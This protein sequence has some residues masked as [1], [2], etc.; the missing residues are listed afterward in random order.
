MQLGMINSAWFGSPYDGRPGLEKMKEIGFDAVDV[1]ADPLDL[2]A[3]RGRRCVRDV[4][5]VG[6]A[7]PSV[8]VVAFG[9]SDFNP[10]I[11]RFHLDRAKG[12]SISASSSGAKLMVVALGEYIW[13]HEV[14]PPEAQWH[15]AVDSTRELGDYAAARGL[16]LA[17]ELEP[18]DISTR[19]HD[20]QAREVHRRRRPPRRQGEPRLLASLAD[21]TR[22]LRDPQ[23][24]GKDHPHALLR[25]QRRDPRRSAARTWQH[26]A[27]PLPRGARARRSSTESSRSSWSTPRS[28]TRSS[29]GSRKRTTQPPR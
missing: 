25:L 5:E 18:F 24:Q 29:S 20:R 10:S 23:A 26:A 11:R 1:L 15:W 3:E 16:E 27:D 6:L 8:I 4:A 7:L 28:P 22:R 17:M 9:F 12:S 19:Q 13:Q 14:I 21:G 2:S